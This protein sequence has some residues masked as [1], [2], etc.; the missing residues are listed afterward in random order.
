VLKLVRIALW[1]MGAFVATSGAGAQTQAGAAEDLMRRSGLWEQLGGVAPQVRAGLVDA[2]TQG[3]ARPS[4]TEMQ[5]LERAVDTAY[6]PQRLRAT[7]LA[8]LR[9]GLD[10]KHVAALRRWY[11]TPNGKTITAMEERASSDVRDPRTVVAEG[12]QLLDEMPAARREL[13]NELVTVTRAADAMVQMMINISLAT[14]R[15]ASSVAPQLPGASEA[16]MR[17]MLEAQRPQLMQAYTVMLLASMAQTY[18]ALPTETLAQYVGF[19]KSSA[20]RHFNDVTLKAFDAAMVEA[21]TD[22]G[23]RLPT[24][25]DQAN[26]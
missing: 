11:A 26:T 24:S 8:Q 19:L 20:G 17:S 14:Q 21:A 16:Q 2:L 10:A 5:R 15:G 18:A 4:D 9:R 7:A 22:L 3:G 6:A 12:T 1:C 23:R 25:K 13:L